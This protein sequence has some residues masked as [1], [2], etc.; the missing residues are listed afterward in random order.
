MGDKQLLKSPGKLIAFLI[1]AG[2]GVAGLG[3]FLALRP[4]SPQPSTPVSTAEQNTDNN[5]TI[6]A[7]GRLE[8]GGEVYC[9]V[10]PSS[11]GLSSVI[12]KWL[13]KEGDMVKQNQP[14]A[15]VDTYDRLYAAGLQAEA[16]VREAQ[17]KLAQAQTGAKSAEVAAQESQAGA[18]QSLIAAREVEV[19]KWEAEVAIA[20]RDYDRYATLFK[21][22][23]VSR[24][25]L[26]ER[27]LKLATRTQSLNQAKYLLQQSAREF[28]Q[29]QQSTAGLAQVRPVDVQQ[30]EAQ[31]Q[32]ALANLQ[33]AKV[34]LETSAVRSPITGRVLKINTKE[35]EQASA[36]I[37]SGGGNGCQGVAELGRVD[38][39]YAVAEVYE[40]DVQ[41]LKQGQRATITSSAFPGEIS[42]TVQQIGLLIRK[43][44]VLNTDPAAN[45]DVRIVE[46]KIRLDDSRPIA[47]LTNLQVKVK[48]QP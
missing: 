31:V 32:V 9:V 20:K 1:A 46:T 29:A 37:G 11:S 18:R 19:R 12:K 33:R 15:V 21:D 25:D 23:A 40:T 17:A 27:E 6:T 30:A 28:Q 42:G 2:V 47:G 10:P 39:M 3:I 26:D 43:N 7:L 8:P 22:G 13:V 16:Q 35:S 36:S 24:A 34:D 38:Q 44:D 4:S 48:I 41:R 45:T 14:I 5:Q